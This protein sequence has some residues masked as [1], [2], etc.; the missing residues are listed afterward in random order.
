MACLYGDAG[1]FSRRWKLPSAEGY[2]MARAGCRQPA[3]EA[4]E[5]AYTREALSPSCSGA[6]GPR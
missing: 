4:A 6:I 1:A 2:A 5:L 3:L